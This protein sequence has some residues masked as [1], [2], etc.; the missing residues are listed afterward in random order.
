VPYYRLYFM[1]PQSGH[2]ERFAEYEAP[3]DEAALALAAE[4][5]GERPLELWCRHR[6]VRTFPAV[7][8]VSARSLEAG[9]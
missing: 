6:K 7:S 2:I 8:T 3:D 4:H 5:E 1:T 9:E